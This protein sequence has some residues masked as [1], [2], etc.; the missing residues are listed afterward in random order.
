MSGLP[1]ECDITSS[2]QDLVVCR[3]KGGVVDSNPCNIL[4]PAADI[5]TCNQ[6]K[7]ATPV[8]TDGGNTLRTVLTFLGLGLLVI[9]GFPILIM[10]AFAILG[11]I[12]YMTSGPTTATV[13][14]RLK[15]F[16]KK[17]T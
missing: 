5:S 14:G 6:K 2:H 1:D 12:S 17:F 4:N 8:T 7:V 10:L 13:G 3:S 9:I 16:L 15:G 11:G